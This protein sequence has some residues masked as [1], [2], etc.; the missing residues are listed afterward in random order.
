MSCNLTDIRWWPGNVSV[1]NWPC[2]TWQASADC[3]EATTAACD[4]SWSGGWPC[5]A[6][7]STLAWLQVG[8]DWRVLRRSGAPCH[9]STVD[10]FLAN[11]LA[12][13]IVALALVLARFAWAR[14]KRHEAYE[15]ELLRFNEPMQSYPPTSPAHTRAR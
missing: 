4:W 5:F 15:R 9:D 10:T 3:A 12:L 13:L 6:G 2:A 14:W 1:L 8:A 7:N 11:L